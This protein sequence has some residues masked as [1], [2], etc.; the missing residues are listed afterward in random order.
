MAVHGARKRVDVKKKPG[1]G[2]AISR[3]VQFVD[4]SATLLIRVVA[5]NWA[6]GIALAAFALINFLLAAELYQSI[7]DEPYHIAIVEAYSHQWG[8]RLHNSGVTEGLGDVEYFVS[9]LYHY[10]LSFPA[11]VLT[12]L[13]VDG[14]A[15]LF[16]LRSFSVLFITL[17]LLVWRKVAIILGASRGLAN[18]IVFALTAIP[19]FSTL[20]TMVNYDSLLFLTSSLVAMAAV[21][22]VKSSGLDLKWW[23]YFLAFGAI[24]LMV[25]YTF[26]PVF[27]VATVVL[28]LQNFRGFKFSLVQLFRAGYWGH[29][30]REGVP[31]LLLAIGV[32]VP[33][34][35]RYLRNL[36]QWGQVSPACDVVADYEY[37]IAF[38]PF[39]R[40]ERLDAD[41]P[42][43]PATIGGAIDYFFQWYRSLVGTLS[44]NGVLA[45][46]G[47]LVVGSSGAQLSIALTLSVSALLIVLLLG[48]NVAR[49][50]WAI[51]LAM[52]MAHTVAQYM[53]N[54]SEFRAFGAMVGVSGRYFVPYIP[55]LVTLAALGLRALIDR[56]KAQRAIWKVAI[57]GVILLLATQGGG[58]LTL[59]AHGSGEFFVG[60]PGL[61]EPLEFLMKVSKKL[62]IHGYGI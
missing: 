15:W 38:G 17:G 60:Q 41:F 57:L 2:V 4:R 7:I 21:R 19:V 20:A 18:S 10:A 9:F 62:Y 16:A 54:F 29:R 3:G 31:A 51:L 59:L 61:I 30:W 40:N 48:R 22:V 46:G 6:I 53:L 12:W 1:L 56:F 50:N 13:G 58:P 35:Y 33:A 28:I 23:L 37:C 44:L 47:R 14:Q 25:K 42:D 26:A 52:F 11:R 45:P 24:S 8:W 43:L 39:G 32:T 34:A 49:K 36:I 27:L 55:I 5:S